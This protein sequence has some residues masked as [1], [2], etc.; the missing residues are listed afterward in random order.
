MSAQPGPTKRSSSASTASTKSC[1]RSFFSGA[2]GVV[3]GLLGFQLR[4]AGLVADLDQLGDQAAQALALGD[5]CAGGV[6]LVRRDGA[7]ARLAMDGV[8]EDPA[9]A[10]AGMVGGG[11]AAVGFAALA[12]GLDEGAGAQIAEVGQLLEQVLAAGG[13]GLGGGSGSGHGGP[14][15]LKALYTSRREFGYPLGCNVISLPNENSQPASRPIS[16]PCRTPR[17]RRILEYALRTVLGFLSVRSP[18][19]P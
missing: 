9:R 11:A 18:L 2:G 10:V 1:A 7:G 3:G 15:C 8:R 4:L 13:E 5:L 16:E 12:V 19:L 14:P 6:E 17:W